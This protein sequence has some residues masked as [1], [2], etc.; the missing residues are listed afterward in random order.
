MQKCVKKGVKINWEKMSVTGKA[1]EWRDSMDD[2]NSTY[3]HSIIYDV[4]T[5][6]SYRGNYKNTISERQ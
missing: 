2:L 5:V 4:I 6:V 1:C 3:A